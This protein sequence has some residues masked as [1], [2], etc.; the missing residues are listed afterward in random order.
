MWRWLHIKRAKW[1]CLGR[2]SKPTR[3]RAICNCWTIKHNKHIWCLSNRTWRIYQS[4]WI[5]ATLLCGEASCSCEEECHV[6]KAPHVINIVQLTPTLLQYAP[7]SE[8]LT[9]EEMRLHSLLSLP[10]LLARHTQGREPFVAYSQS[11]VVTSKCQ[12][13][14]RNRSTTNN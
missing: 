13:G 7:I 14:I 11:R 3:W 4:K 12:S 2:W 6:E 5:W 1:S 10:H 8:D 9:K